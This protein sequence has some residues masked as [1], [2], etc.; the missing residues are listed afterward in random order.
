MIWYR[1]APSK[2]RSQLLLRVFKPGTLSQFSFYFRSNSTNPTTR[3][4]S[5]GWME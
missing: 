4:Q 5:E 3:E 2:N 1:S